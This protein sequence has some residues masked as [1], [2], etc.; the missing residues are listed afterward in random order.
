VKDDER[1][2]K[3]VFEADPLPRAVNAFF[4]NVS[5]H[6]M[7]FKNAWYK[8]LDNCFGQETFKETELR[9]K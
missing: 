3:V 2:S 4:I 8:V 5:F 6:Q 7:N 9:I 1:K